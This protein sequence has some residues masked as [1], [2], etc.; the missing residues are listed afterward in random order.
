MSHKNIDGG[1]YWVCPSC[2]RIGL[3]SGCLFNHCSTDTRQTIPI[4]NYMQPPYD[5][6]GDMI[7]QYKY[8][9]WW[10]EYAALMEY[11]REHGGANE[12][13]EP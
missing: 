2:G 11:E 8:G 3:L 9:R 5:M 10:V 12:P 1:N 6:Y 7:P 13:A 4:K